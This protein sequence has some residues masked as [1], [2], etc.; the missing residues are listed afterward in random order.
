MIYSQKIEALKIIQKMIAG[1]KLKAGLVK[2][3]HLSATG[4]L[5]KQ[6]LTIIHLSAG[7]LRHL[8]AVG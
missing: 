1:P 6:E 5:R 4:A 3:H 8:S 7:R 2:A